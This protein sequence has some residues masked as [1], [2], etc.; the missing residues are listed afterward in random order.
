MKDTDSILRELQTFEKKSRRTLPFT[1]IGLAAVLIALYYSAISLSSL[2][3]ELTAETA[4]LDHIRTQAETAGAQLASAR[5]QLDKSNS[6]LV[7]VKTQLDLAN[8]QVTKANADLSDLTSTINVLK[9]EK[10][11]HETKVGNLV[12]DQQKLQ[13]QIDKLRGQIADITPSTVTIVTSNG[14]QEEKAAGLK[15][16]FEGQGAKVSILPQKKGAFIP[17]ATE[18][19]YF[20]YPKDLELAQAIVTKLQKDFGVILSRISYVKDER[21]ERAIDIYFNDHKFE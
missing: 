6:Q 15:A 12:A 21:L 3:A 1:L 17:Y 19:R 2:R 9:D 5:T 11:A 10:R 18:V 16:F 4:Q 13:I 7:L 14:S 8:T 20:H